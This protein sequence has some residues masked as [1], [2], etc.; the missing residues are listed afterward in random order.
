MP[1]LLPSLLAT[2]TTPL[3]LLLLLLHLPPTH[4]TTNT[5]NTSIP[6][7]FAP[8]LLPG[9]AI[10][11]VG[12]ANFSLVATG[13]WTSWA[14]PTWAGAV[15]PQTEADVQAVVRVA[16]AHGLGFL[17]T[18]GG[19]GAGLGYRNVTGIDISLAALNAVEIDLAHNEMT[20]GAGVLIGD[21]VE[22]LYRVG[23][24]IRESRGPSRPSWGRCAD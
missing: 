17:A 21:V 13:R 4:A 19:H 24:A 11:S 16:A 10:A 1:S 3:F 22:P 14:A 23:K 7:L 15:R 2:T 6:A 5:T 18:A 8:Y 20:V 9:T 12:D